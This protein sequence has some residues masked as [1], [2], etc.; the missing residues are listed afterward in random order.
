MNQWSISVK[1]RPVYDALQICVNFLV[2]FEGGNSVKIRCMDRVRKKPNSSLKDVL[3]S[4]HRP[5]Q[6]GRVLIASDER[7]G[8]D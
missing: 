8:L 7:C 1:M 2:K 5:G 3:I 6:G 4:V